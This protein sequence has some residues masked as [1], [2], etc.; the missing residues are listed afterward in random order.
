MYFF[1]YDRRPSILTRLHR[2][3]NILIYFA[4]SSSRPA[5][6]MFFQ[7]TTVQNFVKNKKT[8]K[9]VLSFHPGSSSSVSPSS[10]SSASLSDSSSSS[11][12]VSAS[13]SSSPSVSASSSSSSSA[14]DSS[15]SSSSASDSS[16][17]SSI[18]S[19]SS[20]FSSSASASSSSSSSA[21]DSSSSSASLSDSSSSSA[22][23]SPSSSSSASLSGQ[24]SYLEDRLH[25]LK[26]S[27]HTQQISQI[28]TLTNVK[29]FHISDPSNIF[30]QH[31]HV[32]ATIP[33]YQVN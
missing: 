10:S 30:L 2:V 9:A 14:S 13:S 5:I 17:S 15:F 16:S 7:Y 33:L 3:G 23:V 25:I 31:Q 26:V 4:Q 22:S 18:A 6:T 12:S 21:S 32:P 19:D 24:T 1:V 27:Y 20:S 8:L 29:K 11:T 28:F